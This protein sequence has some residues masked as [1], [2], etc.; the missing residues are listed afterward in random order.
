MDVTVLEARHL[1]KSYK[2]GFPVLADF[3][4]TLEAGRIMGLL[5]PN[6]CGKTTFLKLVAGLLTPDGGELLLGGVPITDG[7]RSLISYLPERPYFS[8]YMRVGELLRYFADFY[9]DFDTGRA[10]KMLRDLQID[11]ASPMRTLSKGTKEK[12]QLVLVMARRAALYLLDEPIGG[13]DPA[14][15]DYILSTVVQ[16]YAPESAVLI[17]T[18]L[19]ADVEPILDEFMFMNWGGQ[20]VMGG[21]ADDIRAHYGR[22]LDQLFREVFRYA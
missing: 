4:L 15:R 9:P 8:N 13:V 20:I 6:G 14:S 5:G 18:H 19:I 1:R 16:N 3:N 21:T 22:S 7:R 11:P 12:V 10:E 17:T 2:N